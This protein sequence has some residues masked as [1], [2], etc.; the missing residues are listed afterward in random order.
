MTRARQLHQI[1][2]HM[3]KS[4]R[5]HT[6]KLALEPGVVEQRDRLVENLAFLIVRMFRRG[7]SRAPKKPR[8]TS[9]NKQSK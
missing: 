8:H 6:S 9:N 5:K 1:D 4:H 3:A 2:K 7:K